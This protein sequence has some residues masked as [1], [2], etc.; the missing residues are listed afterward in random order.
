MW[1]VNVLMWNVCD[2]YYVWNASLS[3]LLVMLDVA[4]MTCI[5][6]GM[7]SVKQGQRPAVASCL[8]FT[9]NRLH[10]IAHYNGPIAAG[11]IQLQTN[12]V[13]VTKVLFWR[14]VS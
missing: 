13:T 6:C 14:K 1:N 7:Y 4:R 3:H 12:T 2:M 8:C 10:T 11:C 9:A 5:Q